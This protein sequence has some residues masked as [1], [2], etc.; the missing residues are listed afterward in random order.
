MV[1]LIAKNGASLVSIGRGGIVEASD[2]ERETRC[3]R[4]DGFR[5][6]LPRLHNLSRR[7]ASRCD[8]IAK[9][10]LGTRRNSREGA[11]PD[12]KPF[13]RKLRRAASGGL[14]PP[15]LRWS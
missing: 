6:W 10:R 2:A 3:G 12:E 13:E 14:F 4:L 11:F 5:A 15:R 8:D 7:L 9:L 1:R